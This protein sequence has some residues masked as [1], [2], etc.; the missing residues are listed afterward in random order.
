MNRNLAGGGN[1]RRDID[2]L[3][4]RR[5][6]SHGHD[7]RFFAFAMPTGTILRRGPIDAGG[8]ESNRESLVEIKEVVRCRKKAGTPSQGNVWRCSWWSS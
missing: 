4:A 6:D 3:H 5:F 2:P 1:R 8:G 7:H